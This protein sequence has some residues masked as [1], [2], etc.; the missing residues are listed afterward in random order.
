[1]KT[2]LIII[3]ILSTAGLLAQEEYKE[4][5]ESIRKGDSRKPSPSSLLK[6][7]TFLDYAINEIIKSEEIIYISNRRLLQLFEV[8]TCSMWSVEMRDTIND[9]TRIE[10]SIKTQKFNPDANNIEKYKK[11][12][13]KDYIENINNLRAYGATYK[14]PEIEFSNIQI[15]VNNFPLDIPDSAFKNLY[16]PNLCDSYGFVRQV[17]A[18]T[19]L[20]GK[21]IYI[22]IYGGHAADTY[23]TK[24]IFDHKRFITKWTVEYGQLSVFGCFYERFIGY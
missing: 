14:L 12:E 3:T 23:F 16:E 18:Y 24:L 9:T 2:L 19:S 1:M 17:Q 15:L 5:I 11:E 20:D 21:Y 13:Y 10:I 6:D 22:Y 8:D 7:T 4:H